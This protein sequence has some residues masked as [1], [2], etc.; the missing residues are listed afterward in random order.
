MACVSEKT[1]DDLA[2]SSGRKDLH[3]QPKTRLV[4]ES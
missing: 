3:W 1:G 4:Y 2:V